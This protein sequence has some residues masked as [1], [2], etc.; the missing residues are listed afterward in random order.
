V[1]WLVLASLTAA[2][3][4]G[5]VLK[6]GVWPR[7][8]DWSVLVI[9]LA[10]V[11]LWLLSDQRHHAP[12]DR[13]TTLLIAAFAGWCAL[14]LVP[15]PVWLVAFLS[16]TRAAL[17]RAAGPVGWI[18][19]SIA[20]AH[21]FE[22]LLNVGAGVVTLLVARDLAWYWRSRPWIP[23]APLLVL[24]GLEGL[25]GLVQFY[26]QRMNQT[27]QPWS[28]G[29][30]VN[31]N[32]FAGFLEM[33]LPLAV[34]AAAAVWRAGVT[35]HS[36]PAAPAVK[37]SALLAL[38]ALLLAAIVASQSRMGFVAALGGLLVTGLLAAG[39][40]EQRMYG[41]ARRWR[42][43]I[44]AVTVVLGVALLFILLPTRELV[45][46]FAAMAG[47]GDANGEVRSQIWRETLPLV[48]A[49]PLTGC[50]LGTFESA[51]LRYKHVA[52]MFIVDY[53]HN[54][55]LQTLAE[56][57]IVGFA[58]GL[59]LVWRI[60][61]RVVRLALFHQESPGWALALGLAGGIAALLL[62]SLTDFN[63]YIPANAMTL[64]WICGLAA[65][66]ALGAD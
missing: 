25:L 42:W 24:A 27:A 34:A 36:R 26:L 19:L 38:A 40:T 22:C 50:G 33:I 32:H 55:Y 49:Y 66:P 51:F 43:I 41:P 60:M 6:G 14:Q 13:W 54:D 37:A 15:L 10:A 16:P 18:P 65:G 28:T 2:L 52:P 47:T 48:R 9:A 30:F 62:H 31:R 7:Q 12:A 53:A 21:T 39:A 59:A 17:A 57:G 56:L 61:T 3:A 5:I 1:R 45:E 64:A 63:L 58:L 8:W 11:A 23:A 4:T 44:P 20:P 29:T 35:R 46:R